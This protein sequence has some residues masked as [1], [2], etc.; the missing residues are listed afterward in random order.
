L[1]GALFLLIASLTA[2]LNLG[3]D[4]PQYPGHFVPGFTVVAAVH[5]NADVMAAAALSL[6]LKMSV[7]FTC[8]ARP[9]AETKEYSW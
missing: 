7:L 8:L 2:P 9:V 4:F 5:V 6:F 1:H 3:V